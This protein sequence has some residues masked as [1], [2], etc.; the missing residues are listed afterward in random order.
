MFTI[1]NL[2]KHIKNEV[3][4]SKF[5][6]V[7]EKGQAV[8]LHSAMNIINELLN[9]LTGSVPIF[10]GTVRLDGKDVTKP[11]Q[12]IGVSFLKEGV[13]ERLSVLD[14]FK[15]YKGLFGSDL[16]VDE[17]LHLVQLESKKDEKVKKLSY[18]EVRRIQFARIIFQDPLL[19]VFEEPD[20]SVDMETKRVFLKIV[21]HL[22]E[23]QKGILILTGNIESAITLADTAYRLNEKGLHSLQIESE[24]PPSAD[25][26]DE[27]PA[28]SNEPLSPSFT[29]NKI[30]ARVEKKILLFDPSEIDYIESSGGE[31]TI[32]V[33]G[34]GFQGFFTL[35]EYEEKLASYGYFRCHRSYLVNLQKVTEVITWTRNAYGLILEDSSELPLSKNKMATLKEILGI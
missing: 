28:E 5:D 1:K 34:E 16:I 10:Q 8:S 21:Q 13:Y 12:D 30:P 3:V 25:L 22:Q 19:F 4:F 24:Q 23:R 35:T 15:F 18:S 27:E 6:L 9:V 33:K 2:E 32:H 31:V 14:N 26:E 29:F 7:I 20:Q 11:N 17:V